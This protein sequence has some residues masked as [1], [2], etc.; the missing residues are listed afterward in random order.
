[1]F[2]VKSYPAAVL[3]SIGMSAFFA[4]GCD[5]AP[6]KKS[7]GQQDSGNQGSKVKRPNPVIDAFSRDDIKEVEILPA[8]PILEPWGISA[9]NLVGVFPDGKT[10]G[11]VP[12]G[13]IWSSTNPDVA[14]I[15][16]DSGFVLAQKDGE[17]EITAEYMKFKAVAKLRVEMDPDTV[18]TLGEPISL[19][20]NVVGSSEIRLSW[21]ASPARVTGHKLVYNVLSVG[22]APPANCESTPLA[23]VIE[24]K[25]VES[26]SITN[27]S[28]NTTYGFRI[29]SV[30]EI[31]L[32]DLKASRIS[33]GVSL[34]ATSAP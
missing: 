3:L 13:V 11:R 30:E 18:Y 14:V 5:Q 10:K 20:S 29:C 16:Q 26:V 1:M 34:I 4:V 6:F 24:L 27:L 32:G 2:W 9:F 23:N 28:A 22:D 19:K 7:D 33:S 21:I 25:M 8:E 31:D 15:G 12:E 17:T